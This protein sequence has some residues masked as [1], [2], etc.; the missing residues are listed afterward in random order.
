M[1][2]ESDDQY[3][4]SPVVNTRF[5][6]NLIKLQFSLMCVHST[7]QLTPSKILGSRQSP[8]SDS[9]GLGTMA[10]T[11]IEPQHRNAETKC[12]T[13]SQPNTYMSPGMRNGRKQ[14]WSPRDGNDRE[15]AG[16]LTEQII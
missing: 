8:W 16:A 5:S 9:V 11:S 6:Y 15:L 4:N 10:G 3:C 2:V 1:L 12:R 7:H 13:C 14:I